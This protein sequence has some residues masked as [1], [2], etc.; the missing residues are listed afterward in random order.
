MLSKVSVATL[1]YG[2][3]KAFLYQVIDRLLIQSFDEV[4]IYCN[5]ISVSNLAEVKKK[6][7]EKRIVILHSN[8]NL[9]S[10]GGFHEL[11][12]Y[13]TKNSKSEYILLLDDDNLVPND[14]FETISQLDIEKNQL[15]SFHRSD[16]ML[17]KRVKELEKPEKIIGSANSFLGRDFFSLFKKSEIV[18][19]GDLAAAPYGG[20]LLSRGSLETGVLPKKELYLYA[21]DYEYT[22]RLVTQYNFNIVFSE[23]V[24]IEDLEKSFHL[25]KGIRLLSN[26]Y[27]NASENQLYYS[28]RNN[29][30][31]GLNRCKSKL[32]FLTNIV[33]F[34]PIFIGQFLLTL[35][36]KRAKTFITAIKDGFAFYFSEKNQ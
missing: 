26:R 20:L 19:Q 25:K 22:Y 7:R 16:R 13:I 6:Y 30:W 23:A 9:G 29:T 32:L 35:K 33:L 31:L 4:F 10:A 15:Y 24:L 11:L 2:D 3:R 28:V 17:A 1:T 27:S 14:C 8:E 34:S 5:G 12:S 18:Y 21:D 36:L